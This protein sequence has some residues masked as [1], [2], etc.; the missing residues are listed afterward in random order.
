MK[1]AIMAVI[2]AL[3]MAIS[4]TAEAG[5]QDG[6]V[7]ITNARPDGVRVMIDRSYRGSV[8]P[9]DAEAFQLSPGRHH[10][11]VTCS[12]GYTL[13]EETVHIDPFE[14]EAITVQAQS[15]ALS[16]S[17]SAGTT[18]YV[19]VDGEP[20]ATLRPNEASSVK[21]PVG[22][23][24]VKA[25]YRQHDRKVTLS[26]QSVRFS[27][28]QTESIRFSPA[29][30]G[31]V[32]VH[33]DY[34]Q[35]ARILINGEDV[36]SVRAGKS[37]VVE[38]PL[39]TVRMELLIGNRIV[40]QDRLSV[41]RYHDTTFR[42]EEPVY[43][44]GRLELSNHRAG[45]AK[46]YVDGR[47]VGTIPAWS[48]RTFT[49]PIGPHQ[50]KAISANQRV[51]LNRTVEIDRYREIELTLGGQSGGSSSGTSECSAPDRY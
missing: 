15:A 14:A 9:A 35:T 39:G 30:T 42:A 1:R 10:V 44:E 17:N 49:L 41:R 12:K 29:S 46:I 32:K 18:L 40:A 48:E 47:L 6:M 19:E 21:I 26:S 24:K 2:A 20:M 5:W 50:V 34:G 7:S 25:Y 38:S 16:M 31:R 43:A 11:L 3:G 51:L 4:G 36:G 8:M 37:K 28:G 22:A 27:P 45:T 33:N 13:A 23:H